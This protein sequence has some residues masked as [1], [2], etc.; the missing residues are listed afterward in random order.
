MGEAKRRREA[1]RDGNSLML[2]DR[3]NLARIRASY[4]PGDWVFGIG[5]HKGCSEVF[6]GRNGALYPFAYLNDYDPGHYRLATDDEVDRAKKAMK[7]KRRFHPA[8][9]GAAQQ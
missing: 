5:P 9:M 8:E 4:Q 2:V 1:R 7:L 6:E 3:D